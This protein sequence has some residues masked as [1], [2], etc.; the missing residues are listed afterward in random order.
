MIGGKKKQVSFTIDMY[1][2]QKLNSLK[3]L[4]KENKTIVSIFMLSTLYY[5]VSQNM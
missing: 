5:I 2:G 1:V 4:L 3:N